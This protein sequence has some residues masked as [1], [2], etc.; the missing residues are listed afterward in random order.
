MFPLTTR[1]LRASSLSPRKGFLASFL[2]RGGEGGG[3]TLPFLRISEQGARGARASAQNF[4]SV[5]WSP[6]TP[7]TVVPLSAMI[8]DLASAAFRAWSK[9]APSVSWGREGGGGRRRVCAVT[10]CGLSS[11]HVAMSCG[12]FLVVGPSPLADNGPICGEGGTL[13]SASPSRTHIRAAA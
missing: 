6:S 11:S 8:A 4:H 12:H 3:G 13:P 9:T 2:R 5:C 7:L 10:C 1:V